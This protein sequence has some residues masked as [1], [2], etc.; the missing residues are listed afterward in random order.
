M[1]LYAC[2]SSK[3]PDQGTEN[4]EL[5]TDGSEFK[6]N[7]TRYRKVIVNACRE[8]R[9][10]KPNSCPISSLNAKAMASERESSVTLD[11]IETIL[12]WSGTR[13]DRDGVS[14]SKTLTL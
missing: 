10:M 3:G 6:N 1:R 8:Y 4:P 5:Q 7:P 2:P 13:T 11:P 12:I 9:E 14:V